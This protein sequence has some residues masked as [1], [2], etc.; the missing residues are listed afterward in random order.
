MTVELTEAAQVLLLDLFEQNMTMGL[1]EMA[2]FVFND[3]SPYAQVV[4]EEI[5]DE[6]NKNKLLKER[7]SGDDRYYVLSENGRE[8]A[9][10]IKNERFNNG[11]I[12]V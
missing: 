8:E 7:K 1:N 4:L 5:Y 3:K 11:V 10:K 6:L 2:C 9:E 12:R